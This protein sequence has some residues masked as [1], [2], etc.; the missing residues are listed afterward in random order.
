M[1]QEEPRSCLKNITLSGG[2]STFPHGAKESA[3][4]L[5]IADKP[6]TRNSFPAKTAS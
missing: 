5:E 4:L 6:F 1:R 2:I 3:R